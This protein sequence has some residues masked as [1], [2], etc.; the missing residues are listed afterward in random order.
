MPVW[1]GRRSSPFWGQPDAEAWLPDDDAPHGLPVGV[2]TAPAR[3]IA[4]WRLRQV[5][6]THLQAIALDGF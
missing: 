6:Q 2:A 3:G 5:V 4:P 1:A